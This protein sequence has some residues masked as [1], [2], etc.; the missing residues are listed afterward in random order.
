MGLYFMIGKLYANSLLANLNTR[1]QLRESRVHTTPSGAHILPVMFPDSEGTRRTRHLQVN[2]QKV[3]DTRV[4][5]SP[6]M[7]IGR[8]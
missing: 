1:K 3:V 2:M 7:S 4:D 8:Y 6:V 5:E